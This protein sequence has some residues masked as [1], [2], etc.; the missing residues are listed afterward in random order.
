MDIKK[1]VIYFLL[2]IGFYSFTTTAYSQD[3]LRPL[4]GIA[5]DYFAMPSDLELL[6]NINFYPKAESV[7]RGKI[8]N[9][10]TYNAKATSPKH[11]F[12]VSGFGMNFLSGK[13]QSNNTS[14]E[15]KP[16]SF[17]PLESFFMESLF[18]EPAIIQHPQRRR[19]IFRQSG[20]MPITEIKSYWIF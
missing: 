4:E 8:E 13:L 10:F 12:G 2:C 17:L 18:M 1:P 19:E 20:L 15:F 14:V 3:L 16:Q 7:E 6:K 11:L 5:L 9:P